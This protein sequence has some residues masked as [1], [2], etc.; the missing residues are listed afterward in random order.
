MKEKISFFILLVI[1]L[2]SISLPSF[3]I[4]DYTWTV[5]NPAIEVSSADSETS[6]QD[7]NFLNLDSASAILIEQ[8][9]GQILYEH[10]I[11][12]KLHPASVT[13]V[14]SL[15][16]IMEALD[17][18]KISLD[19]QI[20]CSTNAA[21]MGGSQIWLDTTETLSVNDML[22]AIAVVS[23]I[24]CVTAMAE[25]L[26]GTEENFVQMMND[27]AKELGMNDTTFKNCH[28]LDE[29]EHLTSAYDIA[30]MS[31][32]LLVKH[33]AITNYSTI[34]TDTLRDG[35]SALSNTN[36]LVRNY[37]GCT[38][39]KTGSTSLALFNLS[40][41]ATRD[42]LSLIAVIMKAPTSALR[43]SNAIK[44]LDYGFTNYSYKSFAN[45]GDFIR[46]ISVT[47]GIDSIANVVY[48]TSPSF[49]VKK[50]E[51]SKI[52]YELNLPDTVSAP[53]SKGQQLGT[54]T[55]YSDGA[56]LD[57]VN[58]ISDS[59]INKISFISMVKHISYNWLNLLRM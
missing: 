46:Q 41:S 53:I 48:E 44:L 43:F 51:E 30:L 3:S 10:N 2:C 32:E 34:W 45:R 58:L 11:H 38:G 47:K 21:N 40:A 29:D 55:Y 49:L 18:G 22:K 1:I 9:S 4:N 20:P 36:K 50:G 33:P 17:S 26:G 57:T 25:Y 15:L 16:L 12:E 37:A 31:R 14:M 5:V 7:G 27:K 19:T 24:D 56:K 35:K 52:T 28:G 23:A 39:L 54:I 59:T 42:G 8:N 6:M 13:K